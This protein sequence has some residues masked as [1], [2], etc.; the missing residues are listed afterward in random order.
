[1]LKIDILLDNELHL[2]IEADPRVN[3]LVIIS[4]DAKSRLQHDKLYDSWDDLT[5]AADRLLVKTLTVQ[6]PSRR[7]VFANVREMFGNLTDTAY[8]RHHDSDARILQAQI[9]RAAR[10]AGKNK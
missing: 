2:T 6:S 7:V 10:H 5:I 3:R 9:R 4:N 1:M 8:W